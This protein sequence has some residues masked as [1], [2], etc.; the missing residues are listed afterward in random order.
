VVNQE[1]NSDDISRLTELLESARETSVYGHD[2]IDMYRRYYR[3]NVAEEKKDKFTGETIRKSKYRSRLIKKRFKDRMSLLSES[4]LSDDFLFISSKWNLGYSLADRLLNYQWNV[5]IDKHNVVTQSVKNL[6]VDGT[7]ILKTEWSVEKRQQKVIKEEPILATSADEI[8]DQRMVEAFNSGQQVQVGVKQTESVED[9]VVSSKP[10]VK[11]VEPTDMYFGDGYIIERTRKTYQEVLASASIDVRES[12]LK[13]IFSDRQ[14]ST[15]PLDAY[16]ISS[17]EGDG[18]SLIS[19]QQFLTSFRD[20]ALKKIYVYQY[21][22]KLADRSDSLTVENERVVVWFD[23]VILS[24]MENPYSHK[25][26]PY[27]IAR[28]ETFDNSEFGESESEV[29]HHD[30][31][32]ATTIS[33]TLHTAVLN[34]KSGQTLYRDGFFTPT[35]EKL[36][37]AGHKAKFNKSMDARDSIVNVDFP[38]ISGGAFDLLEIFSNSF[39]DGSSTTGVQVDDRGNN[40]QVSIRDASLLRS[41]LDMLTSVARFIHSMN[42]QLHVGDLSIEDALGSTI[43]SQEYV[44]SLPQELKYVASAKTPHEKSEISKSIE[45]LMTTSGGNMDEAISLS[46]YIELALIGGNYA[47]AMRLSKTLDKVENPPEDPMDQIM[48]EREQ[49]ENERIKADIARM[50]SVSDENT[51]RAMERLNKI[52]EATAHSETMLAEAK[53]M[54]AQ[55]QAEKQQAETD[56]FRNELDYVRSGRKLRDEQ[57]K[58]EYQHGANLEKEK[59]RT[60]RE[61]KFNEQKALIAKQEKDGAGKKDEDI[62]H[63]ETFLQAMQNVKKVKN[64]SAN[65]VGNARSSVENGSYADDEEEK[66]YGEAI[67]PN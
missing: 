59:V 14:N 36:Y 57:L 50:K 26:A 40:L 27:S 34:S 38:T 29:L 9:V 2:R 18:Y 22:G 46:H 52:E 31:T 28:Y 24:N 55:A 64:K 58:D 67:K 15:F 10:T 1:Q 61:L 49:L 23:N 25:Q 42:V 41:Y 44:E 56:F 39:N 33:R 13:E 65:T 19:D 66:Q 8:E 17:Q 53:A 37:R 4:V 54:L 6:V 16:I 47:L 11:V 20:L 60:E 7:A 12:V 30:Q 48:L 5:L 32:A 21:W 43:V 63:P 3:D 62:N 51:A 35:E 45:M